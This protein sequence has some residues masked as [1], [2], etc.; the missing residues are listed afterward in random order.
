MPFLMQFKGFLALFL[1]FAA[2]EAFGADTPANYVGSNGGFWSIAPNWST[3]PVVPANAG[4]N[5]FAVTI[6]A[7]TNVSFDLLGSTSISALTLNPSATLNLG[8]GDNLA[9]L[10]T[11]N[12]AG[13]VSANGAT[14]TASGSTTADESSFSTSAAGAIS[15]PTFS[16]YMPGGGNTFH[17]DGANSKI[18]AA[19][20][21]TITLGSANNYLFL[22]ATGGGLVDAHNLTTVTGTS[23][24]QTPLRVQSYDAGSV[25]NINSLAAPADVLNVDVRGGGTVLWGSPTTLNG[26]V[27]SKSGAT[28]TLNTASLSS[29]DRSNIEAQGGATLAFPALVTYSPASGNSIQADGIGS[30]VD[31]SSLTKIDVGA[32]NNYMYLVA[33]NGGLLDA[34]NLSTIVGTSGI[35]T[36]IRVQS[37]G[38]GSTVNFSS[39]GSVPNML[40]IDV[41][42]GASVLWGSPTTVQGAVLDK[43]GATSTL[44]TASLSNIDHSS[45]GAFTGATMSFPALVTYRP[46]GGN[47]FRA[48]G[49]QSKLDFPALTTIDLGSANNYL[50]INAFNGGTIDAHAL[51]TLTGTSGIG[52]PIRVQSYNT[53]TVVNLGSLVS[54]PNILSLDIRDGATLLWGNPTS[55]QGDIISKSGAA[56]VLNTA[57][58]T[59]I[60]RSSLYA[61]GGATLSFPAVVSYNPG[62]GNEIRGDGA[63]SKID[64]TS[65][66]SLNWGSANNYVF[67]EAYNGGLV[68]ARNLA[69]I[70]GTTGIGLPLRVQSYGAGSNVN[71]AAL[72]FPAGVL[73][74]DLRDGATMTWNKPASLVGQTI[75]MSNN[76]TLDTSA[77]SSFTGGI[78]T[79]NNATTSFAA[80][81]T[82][83]G[84]SFFIQGG[85]AIS[86][87]ALHKI[88]PGT[89]NKLRADGAGSKAD[90]SNLTT[91]DLGLASNFINVEA[92]NGGLVDMHN[93]ASVIG[94]SGTAT[95]LRVQSFGVGSNVNMS[96]LAFT[97]GLLSLDLRDQ[98]T[99]TW[100][101]PASLIGANISLTNGATLDTSLLTSFTN[102][103][104]T[105]TNASSDLSHVVSADGSNLFAQGGAVMTLPALH[106]FAPGVS[107]TFTADGVGSKLDLSALN[108]ID[109][110]LANRTL[111]LNAFNGGVI[112]LHNV[113]AITGSSG[114]TPLHI[115]SFGA[116]SNV[117]LSSFVAGY[118]VGIR[119]PVVGVD[120]RN[121]GAAQ[122]KE[123]VENDV[124]S[125]T[126]T[127]SHLSVD[128][129]LL[130]TSLGRLALDSGAILSV[131]RDFSLALTDTSHMQS[132]AGT[133]MF[134]GSGLQRVEAGGKDVALA[135]GTLTNDNF[136]FGRLIV[137]Q[138]GQPASIVE[139]RD[140]TD[141][142]NRV[143]G[144]PESIY[145]FGIHGRGGAPQGGDPDA[146]D[147][148]GGSTL[149]LRNL[150]VYAEQGGS[151]VNLQTLIPA[152][153]RI[154]AYK[155]GYLSKSFSAVP[156]AWNVDA[157]GDWNTAGNWLISGVPNSA[158]A[159][160]VFG[161]KITA[162]RTVTVNSTDTVG[163]LGFDGGSSYTLSGTGAINL[164][165]TPGLHAGIQVNNDAGNANHT[166]NLPLNVQSDLDLVSYSSGTLNLAGAFNNSAGHTILKDGPGLIAISGPQTH[167]AGTQIVT[168]GGTLRLD[169]DAGS[170][171]SRTVTLN[172][173]GG[174][175]LVTTT[176]HLA[177]LNIVGGVVSVSTTGLKSIV[178]SSVQFGSAGQIDLTTRNGLIVDY[179]TGGPSP[180][181]SIRAAIISGLNAQGT[182]WTGPGIVSSTA[183]SA[184]K[185]A[186]GYTESSALLG[187]N[188][189]NFLGEAVDGSAVL[190]RATLD[191]DANLDG[192]VSFADLVAVAQHYGLTGTS[193]WATGDFN[194][195]GATSFADLVAVAQNYGAVLPASIPGAT[196]DF[197][198]DLAAA[199]AQV[200]EPASLALLLGA[201]LLALRR[202]GRSRR[203]ARR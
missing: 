53:G 184:P 30:I 87:P 171:A 100:N 160:A 93:L 189:G 136:S 187:A 25:V 190:V 18:N 152:G 110:G 65:V 72:L 126:Q 146:V 42:D 103:V 128:G 123:L 117:D 20:L 41:R 83:D 74:A 50:F 78:F 94:T 80:L 56:S 63:G 142:G 198:H 84:S 2:F 49:T 70:S 134:D 46:G 108:S 131:K 48:D 132:S 186:V 125:I 173:V 155:G 119:P 188:G 99:F 166:V 92:Y 23:G 35:G 191:G 104:L 3:N 148:L 133:L 113:P 174:N 67:L 143:G 139:V 145:L 28:S 9:V 88:T 40:S 159:A 68:D 82:A 165:N 45:L 185:L 51:T 14:F 38:S 164:A 177:S 6:P 73:N 147:I 22:A 91:I 151:L 172:Q 27:I 97:S 158:G 168:E 102:G 112:D 194:Y 203:S 81:S 122:I 5:T 36:P 150:N 66:T 55:A 75:S 39:L 107:T 1:A 69:S 89:G 24:I 201:G 15:L 79:L 106:T 115:Q 167:A 105:L 44:N 135:T 86:F 121:G 34:H 31:L 21:A 85:A 180:V 157:A 199:V 141:N 52:Q 71:L 137:G 161:D 181:A 162:A 61:A 127:G 7:S 109:L 12:S 33:T 182:A 120:L 101:K 96:G 200:P 37:Y 163:F 196:P 176:Q 116:G 19:A 60:D 58:L 64:L 98:G 59:N 153:Q 54:T 17:A 154:V 202:G 57:S 175:T 118:P 4:A 129:S 138:A 32:A 11:F 90:F 76:A 26:S 77:L 95:P 193:T 62:N 170:V 130:L 195:D 47:E 140:D 197:E 8:A 111:T 10:N 13:G 43:T 178:T 192:Q 29:L 179:A 183:A 144:A 169:S 114:G 124:I 149:L 156:G 16:S